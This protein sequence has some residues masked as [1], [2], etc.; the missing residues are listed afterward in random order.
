MEHGTIRM[1][2]DF[3]GGQE[4]ITLNGN[5]PFSKYVLVNYLREVE[6][7]KGGAILIKENNCL[8]SLLDEDLC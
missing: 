2:T 8:L 3:P 5:K 4:G 6:R 7:D 1:F